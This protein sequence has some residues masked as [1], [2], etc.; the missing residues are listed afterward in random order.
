MTSYMG[1]AEETFYMTSS[2]WRVKIRV[3]CG[4]GER[5]QS[6]LALQHLLNWPTIPFFVFN[7]ALMG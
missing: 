3:C 7:T 1:S 6:V 5:W 2:C 4:E